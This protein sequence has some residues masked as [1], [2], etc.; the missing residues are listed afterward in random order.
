MEFFKW[1]PINGRLL[2]VM[3]RHYLK[4]WQAAYYIIKY[5][6]FRY[7]KIII[8]PFT[9]YLYIPSCSCNYGCRAPSTNYCADYSMFQ[10]ARNYCSCSC[11]Q[12]RFQTHYDSNPFFSLAHRHCHRNDVFIPLHCN[13]APEM[14]F[15]MMHFATRVSNVRQEKNKCISSSNDVI[16]GGW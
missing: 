14:S 11:C 13:Y 15:M 1:Q 10:S 5:V 7:A 2:H 8:I 3:S 4:T 6:S 16:T 9:C 12:P